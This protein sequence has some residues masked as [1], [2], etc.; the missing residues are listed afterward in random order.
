[1]VRK[2]DKKA[3]AN[4]SLSW[5]FCVLTVLMISGVVLVELWPLVHVPLIRDEGEYALCAKVFLNGGLP[6]RD[7]FIQKPPGIWLIYAFAFKVFGMSTSAVHGILLAAVMLSIGGVAETGRRISSSAG[8][9]AALI[10]GLLLLQPEYEGFSANTEILMILPT[11]AAIWLLLGFKADVLGR[12]VLL[13]GFLMAL[14][15]FFKQVAATH[16]LHAALVLLCLGPR[17]F[18]GSMKN[19]WARVGIFVFPAVALWLG[20]AAYFWIRGGGYAFLD[21]VWLHNFEYVSGPMGGTALEFLRE[22]VRHVHLF[23]FMILG[24]SVAACIH[25]TRKKLWMDLG[26][27]G[28]WLLA[29]AWGLSIGGYFRGHYFIQILPPMAVLSGMSAALLHQFL[30]RYVRSIRFSGVWSAVPLLVLL[31][32]TGLQAYPPIWGMS[33]DEVSMK[34]YSDPRFINARELAGA[35]RERIS[36][37]DRLYVLGSEPQIYFWSGAKP[38]TPYVLANPLFGNYASAGR[39]QEEVWKALFEAP[40]EY[41]ILCFPFSIPLFPASDLTLVGRVLDLVSEQYRTVAWMSRNNFG[42]VLPAINFSRRDFE[43][44]RF[45][46]FL[47]RRE[48]GGKTNWNG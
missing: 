15:S 24:L 3:E 6:H 22:Q 41:L 30:F 48:G 31:V 4:L 25:L 29:S 28:G 32:L 7:V 43:E 17:R 19:R 36:P 47:F 13:T 34:L 26:I 10:M 1:M 11:I 20:A 16:I 39:R 21:S 45:D 14:A 46:L 44:S 8:L 42:K 33:P 23:S 9:W 27:L 18:Q 37:G 38:A 5:F 12:Q 40:P 2:A 35:L